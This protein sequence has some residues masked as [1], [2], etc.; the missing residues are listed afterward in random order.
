MQ[1]RERAA[2][3]RLEAVARRREGVAETGVKVPINFN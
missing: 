1:P 2:D 3:S